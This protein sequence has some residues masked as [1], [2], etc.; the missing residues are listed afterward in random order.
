M[1]PGQYGNGQESVDCSGR[2]CRPPAEPPAGSS[3]KCTAMST[4]QLDVSVSASS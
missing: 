4:C 2:S 1:R 3:S